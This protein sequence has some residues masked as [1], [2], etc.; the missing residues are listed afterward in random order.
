MEK[1]F[2]EIVSRFEIGMLDEASFLSELATNF[3]L[4]T[5]EHH[6]FFRDSW[7][8][9]FWLNQDVVRMLPFLAQRFQLVLLSNTNSMHIDYARRQFPEVFKPIQLQVFSH[10]MGMRKPD[11][12]IFIHTVERADVMADECLYFDDVAKNV[13][14]ASAVGIKSFQYISYGAVREVLEMFGIQ[15]EGHTGW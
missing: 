7:N 2:N 12:Q 9:I 11:T 14:A 3:S 13:E 15:Y 10:E 4:E 1:A 8:D 6:Q 5:N